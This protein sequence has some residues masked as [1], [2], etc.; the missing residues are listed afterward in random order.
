[1]N[2]C[3]PL[4]LYP[5]GQTRPLVI[6]CLAA[7]LL[8]NQSAYRHVPRREA[9]LVTSVQPSR[10]NLAQVKCRRTELSY[11]LHAVRK[12]S[13]GVQGGRDILTVG[14]KAARQQRL[15]QLVGGGGFYGLAV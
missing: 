8:K 9:A 10:G 5:A 6:G 1:M 15:Y 11:A 13:E 14:R 7:G 4:P 3:S 12:L 2:R